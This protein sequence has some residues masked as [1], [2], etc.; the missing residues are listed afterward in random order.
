MKK[1]F[2]GFA[3]GIVFAGLVA[4]ILGFA[5]VRMAASATAISSAGA[6]TRS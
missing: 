6:Q 3:I 5:A 2:L 4:I 1:F